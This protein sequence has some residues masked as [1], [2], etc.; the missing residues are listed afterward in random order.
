MGGH[1]TTLSLKAFEHQKLVLVTPLREMLS[2][3]PLVSGG[4][5]AEFRE[6]T[7]RVCMLG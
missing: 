7:I 5:E 1:C 3:G 6:Q 2:K 4:I